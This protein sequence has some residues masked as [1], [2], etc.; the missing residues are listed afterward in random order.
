M[1]LEYVNKNFT[2]PQK[3]LRRMD[4]EAKSKSMSRSEFIRYLF[5]RYIEGKQEARKI[6]EQAN[7]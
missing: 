4:R 2:M 3:L 1:D 7:K 5:I 6:E